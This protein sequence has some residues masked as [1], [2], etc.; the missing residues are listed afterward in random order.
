MTASVPWST[1]SPRCPPRPDFSGFARCSPKFAKANPTVKGI[2]EVGKAGGEAWK[3][4]GAAEK[5]AYTDKAAAAA[6]KFKKDHP[7]WKPAPKK[8]KKEAAPKAAKAAAPKKA[9]VRSVCGFAC[10]PAALGA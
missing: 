1:R 3:K 6:A 4:L 2:A 7:D 9:A 8:A 5:K 10:V